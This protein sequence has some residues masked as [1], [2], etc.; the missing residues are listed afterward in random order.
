MSIV[1]DLHTTYRNPKGPKIVYCFH[2]WREQ[3]YNLFPFILSASAYWVASSPGIQ[4]K[5][6]P[7]HFQGFPICVSQHVSKKTAVSGSNDRLGASVI[8]ILMAWDTMLSILLSTVKWWFVVQVPPSNIFKGELNFVLPFIS[9][10]L[11]IKIIC[12]PANFHWINTLSQCRSMFC[13]LSM[14][15]EFNICSWIESRVGKMSGY[16]ETIFV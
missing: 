9:L 7:D 4:I 5:Y 12:N 6:Q 16:A 3:I 1:A 10:C 11:Q 15:E 2:Q 13:R 14:Q 8:W